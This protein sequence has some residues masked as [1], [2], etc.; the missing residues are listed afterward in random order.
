MSSFQFIK[1][2]ITFNG[3]VEKN[4]LCQE[5]NGRPGLVFIKNGG[6]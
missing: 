6:N 3:N 1:S 5:S 4:P 2:S